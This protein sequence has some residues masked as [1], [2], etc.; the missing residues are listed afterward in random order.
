MGPSLLEQT[1]FYRG[2][3]CPQ[4]SILSQVSEIFPVRLKRLSMSNGLICNTVKFYL[5]PWDSSLRSTEF[6]TSCNDFA[7]EDCG[8]SK[9]NHP[10]ATVAFEVQNMYGR[11]VPVD[12]NENNGG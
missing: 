1:F 8:D 3:V 10:R 12:K 9:L 4:R 5:A 2:V 7:T 11:I 6:C